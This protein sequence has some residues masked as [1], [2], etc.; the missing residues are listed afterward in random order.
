[1]MTFCFTWDCHE[2]VPDS[3][4]VNPPGNQDQQ[5]VAKEDHKELSQKF[6]LPIKSSQ[7]HCDQFPH[8]WKVVKSS[9]ESVF[10]KVVLVASC[11]AS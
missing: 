7:V 6:H 11:T 3:F 9:Q 8:T 2:L 4:A 5:G 10:V 1:M